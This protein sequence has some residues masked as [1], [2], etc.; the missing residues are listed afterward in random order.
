[1]DQQDPETE[2]EY[3]RIPE[4]IWRCAADDKMKKKKKKGSK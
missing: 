3:C 4:R 2:K 1:M